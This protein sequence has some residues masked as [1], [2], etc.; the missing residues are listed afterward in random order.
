MPN[1]FDH[2]IG[3][4]SNIICT[5]FWL[6]T[7]FSIIDCSFDFRIFLFGSHLGSFSFETV[8]ENLGF[9][10][11]KIV[12]KTLYSLAFPGQD[13]SRDLS[14]GLVFRVCRRVRNFQLS[15]KIW[16]AI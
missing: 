11:G 4:V 16:R 10:P 2:V 14:A 5:N 3:T 15:G 8:K 13:L 9:S 12:V 6:C 7:R 1:R